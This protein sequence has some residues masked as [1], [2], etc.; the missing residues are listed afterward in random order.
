[1]H[2]TAI[3]VPAYKK[4]LNTYDKL[5][6]LRLNKVLRDRSVFWVTYEQLDLSEY[7]KQLPE[8]N[9]IDFH[10][11]YFESIQ[12]YNRLMLNSD[13]YRRFEEFSY[14]LIYQLDA[15]LFRDDLDD[16]DDW[17]AQNYDYI[18]APWINWDYQTIFMN[19][20]PRIRKWWWKAFG[21]PIYFVGNGGFSLRK[22][23]TF[24]RVLKLLEGAA[25]KWGMFEDTFWPLY[26]KTYF[27]WFKIPNY[28]TA[29]KFAYENG[30]NV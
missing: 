20:A 30:T 21:T 9:R 17:M 13:F 22:V 19:N 4:E 27:P 29:L 10:R 23:S 8:A 11:R 25:S 12:G 2:S 15:Y 14:V 3:V 18:G 7:Y 16:L 28:K 5:A 24:I 1:M 26:V 6:L